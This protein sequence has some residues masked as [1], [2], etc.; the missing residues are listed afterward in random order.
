[1][2]R[3]D[4]GVCKGILKH[5]RRVACPAKAMQMY[6]RRIWPSLI[7]SALFALY[8][9][10]TGD[11]VRDDG[12][13]DAS[14]LPRGPPVEVPSAMSLRIYSSNAASRPLEPAEVTA[15]LSEDGDPTRRQTLRWLGLQL[16]VG[17][18]RL[19]TESTQDALVVVRFF[20][21]SRRCVCIEICTSNLDLHITFRRSHPLRCIA[22]H[23]STIT[24]RHSKRHASS[25]H[26][27]TYS[28][29]LSTPLH[30][31]TR[32]CSSLHGT[33]RWRAIC[34]GARMC[35]GAG[36]WHTLLL[37]LTN[38]CLRARCC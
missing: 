2:R 6:H 38:A 35:D 16:H 10:A 24:L 27:A 7:F 23:Y 11:G 26:Y 37:P 15:F 34:F 3:A 30:G 36:S 14:T 17:A 12:V 1:M 32:R 9:C 13:A 21:S 20:S 22:L 8:T 29:L 28:V 25:R 18:D 31:L 33:R 5:T 19:R 4:S